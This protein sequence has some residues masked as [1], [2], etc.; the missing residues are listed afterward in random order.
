MM[1]V[2]DALARKTEQARA[3][4]YSVVS[5]RHIA[6]LSIERAVELHMSLFGIPM[7]QFDNVLKQYRS[8]ANE[9]KDM[10]KIPDMCRACPEA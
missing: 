7:D 5:Y 6:N 4:F 3:V 2:A 9:A 8:C 10:M 1:S